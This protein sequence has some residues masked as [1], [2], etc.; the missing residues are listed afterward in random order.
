MLYLIVSLIA[1]LVSAEQV[2][3]ENRRIVCGGVCI[4][5]AGAAL[6]GVISG[7]ISAGATAGVAAAQSKRRRRFDGLFEDTV[8]VKTMKIARKLPFL[9]ELLVD[10]GQD[11]ML[12]LDKTVDALTASCELLARTTDVNMNQ[13]TFYLSMA[14]TIG[15]EFLEGVWLNAFGNIKDM[16]HGCGSVVNMVNRVIDNGGIPNIRRAELENG[17]EVYITAE[18]SSGMFRRLVGAAATGVVGAGMYLAHIC[19]SFDEGNN[20][21]DGED[22]M[23]FD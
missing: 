4:G 21:I 5:L 7:G 3:K 19:R 8:C 14:K 10:E 20:L 11:N 1:V 12:P 6:G 13:C 18:E 22:V 15:E 9:K 2:E 17:Q 23:S 16:M